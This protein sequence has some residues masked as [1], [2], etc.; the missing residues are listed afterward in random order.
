M[1]HIYSPEKVGRLLY[2]MEGIVAFLCVLLLCVILPESPR[3]LLLRNRA[4]DAEQLREQLDTMLRMGGLQLQPAAVA[5]TVALPTA[6]QPLLSPTTDNVDNVINS[7]V[8]AAGV[9]SL[10]RKGEVNLYHQTCI[11]FHLTLTKP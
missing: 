2:A 7:S 4:A 8:D 11:T 5:Q 3:F 6:Q 9:A 1:C 10:G